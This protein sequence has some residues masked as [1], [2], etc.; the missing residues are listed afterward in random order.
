MNCLTNL[1]N[2]NAGCCRM[3]AF[4]I[5]NL[6]PDMK[7]YYK[8]HNCQIKDDLVI[9]PLVCKALDA[10][11][12]CK[13]HFRGKPNVCKDFKGQTEGHMIVKNCIYE[14]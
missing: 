13:L 4:K 1:K 3:F 10:N 2:C 7:K 5:K 9:I 6:N 14:K 12:R 8:L 11:N